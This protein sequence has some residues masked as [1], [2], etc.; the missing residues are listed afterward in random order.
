MKTDRYDEINSLVNDIIAGRARR[1]DVSDRIAALKGKYGE[2]MFPSIHFQ[3]EP[4]PWSEEYFAK[5]KMKNIT[6]ACSEEFLLHMAE[7]KDE[8]KLRRKRLMVGIVAVT[9]IIFFIIVMIVL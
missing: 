1:G 5:L 4:K 6:G 9:V 8:I 7:V 3:K 2:D